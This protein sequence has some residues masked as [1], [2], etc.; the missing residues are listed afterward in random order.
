MTTDGIIF[1]LQKFSVHD[2][3]GIRTTVFLK[4]C[5]LRCRWC[6]NAESQAA[7]P[8]PMVRGDLCTGCGA[9]VAS[10]PE[11]AIR[12]VG[13][14]PETD[15]AACTR[16]GRCLLF[17]PRNCRAI[18]GERRTVTEVVQ[19]VLKDRVFYQQ[20]GGGVTFSGGEPLEQVDFL[21][22]SLAACKIEKLHT[23]VDTSGFAPWDAF[24]RVLAVTDL[25]LFDLKVM[26]P[27]THQA[28]TGVSNRMI[29]EN[30]V[31]LSAETD[32]IFIRI[33]VVPTVN[34]DADNI[35][36]TID[37]LNSIR[38]QRLHLLPYH[39]LGG[40][41]AGQLGRDSRWAEVAPPTVEQMEAVRDQ[42]A[43]A[44]L[45]PVIGG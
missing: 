4:G 26:N 17:C 43:G 2:G 13:E 40:G 1:N 30:L 31:R 10:C 22:E 21:A 27:A 45:E 34:D 7:G 32:R 25:F 28:Y 24:E 36:Q 16:C 15:L 6:H 33:P 5:P 23:A 39:R 14:R 41:K 37:F 18:C 42:F 19:E 44:G 3:P 11:Q 35:R 20:S 38:F 29:L 9:C 8:E 12:L